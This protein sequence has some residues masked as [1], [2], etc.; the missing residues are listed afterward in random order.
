VDP[1]DVLI[2]QAA[3]SRLI[4]AAFDEV[5]D[6]GRFSFNGLCNEVALR[7]ARRFDDGRMPYEDAD[8]VMNMLW[9]VMTKRAVEEPGLALAETAFEIYEAFDAGEYDHRDGRDPVAAFT[10][11][12]IRD[13]LERST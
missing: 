10:R 12:L 11:P 1:I 13:I 6:G 9:L 3:E 4:D 5:R 8:A 2:E 7:V